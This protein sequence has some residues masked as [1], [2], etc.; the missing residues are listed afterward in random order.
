M[1]SLSSRREGLLH[2]SLCMVQNPLVPIVTCLMH[3]RQIHRIL[4]CI[5]HYTVVYCIVYSCICRLHRA[6]T[7]ERP[8]LAR[9]LLVRNGIKR[10]SDGV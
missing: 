6:I 4:L 3:G 10:E 8:K 5:V 2:L 9:K 7:R 1:Y